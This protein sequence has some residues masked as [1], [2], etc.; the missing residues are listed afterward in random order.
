M[1]DTLITQEVL[2]DQFISGELP[3]V[4]MRL[5]LNDAVVAEQP[6]VKIN[7]HR[8]PSKHRAH[9]G[10]IGSMKFSVT[11]TMTEKTTYDRVDVIGENINFARVNPNG[12]ITV[13]PQ[14]TVTVDQVGTIF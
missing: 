5:F 9:G 13:R 14:E 10:E 4:T 6:N 2:A 12:S 3:R 7:A 11:M 1:A 8:K